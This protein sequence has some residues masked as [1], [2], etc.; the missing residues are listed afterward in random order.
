VL[1]RTFGPKR[2]EATGEWRKLHNE[3]LYDL[4]SSPNIIRV[5]KTIRMRWAG[6]V[7]RMGRGKVH[8]ACWWENPREREHL[9]DLCVN[10]RTTLKRNLTKWHG[11]MEWT[12]LRT[13]SGLLRTW[14]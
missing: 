9:E 5:I 4:H 3:E 13:S 11:G 2:D 8:T 6:H 14:N 10:G 1:R 12:D 7:A